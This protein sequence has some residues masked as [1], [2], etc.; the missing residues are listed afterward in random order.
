MLKKEKQK[1]KKLLQQILDSIN[2]KLC[3]FQQ[4]LEGVNKVPSIK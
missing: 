4:I 2:I 3:G 1:G